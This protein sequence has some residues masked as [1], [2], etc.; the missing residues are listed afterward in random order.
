MNIL[1]VAGFTALLTQYIGWLAVPVLAVIVS[2]GARELQLQ[3]W[4]TGA[5]AALAWGT[6]LFMTSRSAAFPELLAT[7]GGVFHLPGP[8]LLFLALVLPF[9]MGWSTAVIMAAIRNRS[10]S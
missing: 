9:A 4:Q 7:L 5:G 6:L 1:L 10:S 2:L 8:A 3:P